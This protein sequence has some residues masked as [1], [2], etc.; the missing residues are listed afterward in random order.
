VATRM[1][2]AIA[3]ASNWTASWYLPKWIIARDCVRFPDTRKPQTLGDLACTFAIHSTSVFAVVSAVHF[4]VAR[5]I[6]RVLMRVYAKDKGKEK[7]GGKGHDGEKSLD[8]EKIQE[9]VKEHDTDKEK[10]EA[11][12]EPVVKKYSWFLLHAMF[13]TLVTA[14][15]ISDAIKAFLAPGPSAWGTWYGMHPGGLFGGIAIG[16]FHVHHM[17]F[18]SV[19]LEDIIHHTVNAGG[20]VLIGTFCPWGRMTALS[21]MAMCGIPGGLNYFVLWFQ[22]VTHKITTRQQKHVNRY[23]NICVR[24]PIQLICMYHITVA[25]FGD[26]SIQFPATTVLTKGLM[27]V[28]GVLHTLNA[29]YYADQVV[30]NFHIACGKPDR[31][32]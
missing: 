32:D 7:V 13:N 28:G 31:G 16:A 29:L 17:V 12:H 30:G 8:N 3:V 1:M 19:S 18:H 21:N 11:P 14:A 5:K 4:L 6:T 10:K 2:S 25:I 27:L 23:L 15:G 24:L 9:K 20:V 26:G 22:K